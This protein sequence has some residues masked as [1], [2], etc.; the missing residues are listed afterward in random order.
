MRLAGSYHRGRHRLAGVFW[1]G[2]LV[3]C[4][5]G[6]KSV[7][8]SA[9]GEKTAL[10]PAAV[11]PIY[12]P[13]MAKSLPACQTAPLRQG[14][15]V[16]FSGDNTAMQV[17]WQLE[18]GLP[19]VLQWGPDL[20]YSLGVTE[21]AE[22]GPDHRYSYT[23]QHLTPGA[24]YDYRVIAG[25]ACAAGS[26]YA[27]PP[28]T[29]ANLKFFAY[30]DTRNGLS[31]NNALAGQIR[32]A[33]RADPAFQTFNLAVGDLVSNGD[34]ES[35]WAAE[36]FDPRA[37]ALHAVLAEISFL[38]VMGNHEG[39]GGL[40]TRYFPM[41]FTANRYWSFDYG[42]AHVV[43][44]D[45]YVPFSA[46]S[47]QYR[48]LVADLA[49]SPKIWKFMVLHEPG[50]SAGGGHPNNVTVQTDLQPVAEQFGVALILGGHNHYYARAVVNGIQ[51]LTVGGGGAP[52]YIPDPSAA[53]VVVA[54]S[55]YSFAE[56]I[57]RGRV[58]T[59]TVVAVDGTPLDAF[60]VTR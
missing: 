27:A 56:L 28:A 54:R 25:P 41:P 8:L 18:A 19:A 7:P 44:L 51:H 58:L 60:T 36:F 57:I 17:V 12:L 53:Q 2:L 9:S 5:G 16:I 34:L 39:S 4:L 32:A 45:Q 42:P 6:G 1:L 37:A 55:A 52:L 38:P 35:A 30:G 10:G 26:F 43:M 21:T 29:A 20:Q 49:A 31:T 46:G 3:L 11:Q 48:W 14:P 13:F 59:G 50:W 40:F 22:T 23:I 24:R 15:Q 33:Y 47:A